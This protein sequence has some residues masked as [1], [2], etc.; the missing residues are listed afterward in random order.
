MNATV[1]VCTLDELQREGVRV[2]ST[3]QRTAAV[4]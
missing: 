2:V 4:F 1:R 3:G